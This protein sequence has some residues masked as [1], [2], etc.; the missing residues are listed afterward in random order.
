[1]SPERLAL[2]LSR[3]DKAGRDTRSAAAAAVTER[4]VGW[5]ISVRM[6]SPGCGGFFI[7]KNFL[8]WADFIVNSLTFSL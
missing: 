6:K 2:Q 7:C 4:P 5:M 3:L 1:M 8:R